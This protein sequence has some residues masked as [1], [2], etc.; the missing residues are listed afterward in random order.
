MSV[1]TPIQ[2]DSTLDDGTADER[3]YPAE[4]TYGPRDDTPA[5]RRV[6]PD[7]SSGYVEIRLALDCDHPDC[8]EEVTSS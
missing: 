3:I 4:H 5:W 8:I 1:H 7:H 2:A 6:N